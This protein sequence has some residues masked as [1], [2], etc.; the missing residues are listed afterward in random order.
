MLQNEGPRFLCT[1]EWSVR[2][3]ATHYP[4]CPSRALLLLRR[5]VR[6]ELGDGYRG[7]VGYS[8]FS[9][10]LSRP[11][12][13]GGNRFWFPMSCR[14]TRPGLG[15]LVLKRIVCFKEAWCGLPHGGSQEPASPDLVRVELLRQGWGMTQFLM[16][17][18]IMKA[19]LG[20]HSGHSILL[21]PTWSSS[22]H[23]RKLG[24]DG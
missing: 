15:I 21:P 5:S 1:S 19:S 18:R 13:P 23:T 20:F 17:I 16:E 8:R 11:L 12:C 10:T 7:N 22:P 9:P 14:R 6:K 2:G 24:W 4:R 3:S